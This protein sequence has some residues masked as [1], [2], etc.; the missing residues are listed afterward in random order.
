MDFLLWNE[1]I[2]IHKKTL[3]IGQLFSVN[4]FLII[5]LVKA[6]TAR[7]WSD[8]TKRA[9]SERMKVCGCEEKQT[10]QTISY[11][12]YFRDLIRSPVLFIE[13]Y[14]FQISC[15][16]FKMRLM[17]QNKHS[18]FKIES[19]TYAVYCIKKMYIQNYFA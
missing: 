7:V 2:G 19:V 4:T 14:G 18:K 8:E 13:H 1:Y 10:Y 12:V 9:H 15:F 6:K 11:L 17:K 5:K 16:S 3:K